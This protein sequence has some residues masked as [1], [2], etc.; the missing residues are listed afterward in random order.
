FY[1]VY[2]DYYGIPIQKIPLKSD[3]D[4]DCKTMLEDSQHSGG[5][6]FANPNAPTGILLDVDKI[7]EMLA[8]FPKNR[9]MIVDE[10]YVDFANQSVL[11]L[12][13]KHK[14]LVIVRTFSKSFSF[15]GMRLGFCIAHPELIET[16]TKVKNSF[17]HFPVD[18]FTQRAGQ[19]VCK[20]WHY[21]SDIAKTIIHDRRQFSDVLAHKGWEVVP[22]SANF[23][24]AKKLTGESGLHVY[25]YL[26]QKGFLVRYFD[27]P[28]TQDYVRITIGTTDDMKKLADIM[29]SM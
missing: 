27:S 8:G 26:K 25:E 21:Y 2:A 6:I 23:I 14:N 5:M 4:I 13:Q 15:A 9:V 29:I 10:A 12:L 16:V 22:S 20:N 28:G 24:M 3:W 18:A 17:N 7:E 11:P 19:A 1:P